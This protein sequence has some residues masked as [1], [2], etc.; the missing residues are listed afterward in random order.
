MSHTFVAKS[1][2]YYF[3]N[4]DFSGDISLPVP[5][6]KIPFEDLK[7]LVGEFVRRQGMSY[8]EAYRALAFSPDD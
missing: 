6:D 2:N 5:V 4:G 3:H 8:M 7:E 1:G